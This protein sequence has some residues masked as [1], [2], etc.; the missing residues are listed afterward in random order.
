M[1]QN[2]PGKRSFL[3]LTAGF[4]AAAIVFLG[5]TLQGIWRAVTLFVKASTL[6]PKIVYEVC[7]YM[8][9]LDFIFCV[10]LLLVNL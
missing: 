9:L 2:I 1:S 10:T 8:R 3:L 4:T 6:S 7:G 5:L